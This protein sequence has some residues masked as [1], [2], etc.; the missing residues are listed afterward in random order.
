MNERPRTRLFVEETLG[1][2]G[3]VRLTDERAHFLR[4]VLRLE[5]GAVVALFNGRDGEWLARIDSVAKSVVSLSL[6]TRTREQQSA[7]DLW[8]LFAP[9]K[10]GRIDSIAEKATE[11]G[12]SVL[13]PV[14]TRYTDAQRVNDTRLRANAVEAAEQC[15]RLDVPDVRAPAPLERVLADWPEDRPLFLCA[16]AGVA[17]PI[18]EAV[19]DH[20]GKPAAFLIGP[21]GGFAETELDELR[22]RPFVVPVG[23]GPRILRADTAV[24]AALACWQSLAGDWVRDGTDHRPRAQ[25]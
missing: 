8:V 20:A 25:S 22:K 13:W 21:E 3:T 2:A 19:R 1:E 5:A 15:E 16:E 12:A 9:I 17:R 18:A 10:H 4:N 6:T 23:L 11:L 24:F 14:F 7:A